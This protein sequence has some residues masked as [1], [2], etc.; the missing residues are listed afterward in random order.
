MIGSIVWH[1]ELYFKFALVFVLVLL[2]KPVILYPFTY[3]WLNL[4]DVMGKIISKI[5]LSIVFYL[6][7]LPVALVRNLLGKDILLLKKFKKSDRSVFVERNH[8]F[9]MH[10]LVNT[11]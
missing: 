3:I 5:L 10:D 11:F 9:D 7:V 2:I 4:S 6:I 1:F 8:L